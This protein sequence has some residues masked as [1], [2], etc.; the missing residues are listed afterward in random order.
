MVSLLQM[1]AMVQG[2][3]YLPQR[4]NAGTGTKPMFMNATETVFNEE[5]LVT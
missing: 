5:D 1:L 4:N 2:G 3:L